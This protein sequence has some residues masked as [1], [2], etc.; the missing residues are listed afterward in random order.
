[1][2]PSSIAL[3]AVSLSLLSPTDLDAPVCPEIEVR[4]TGPTTVLVIPAMSARWQVWEGFM[5][6]NAD[7]YTTWAVTP[8]GFAGAPVPD[9]PIDA[10]VG[11]PWTDH[12]VQAVERVLQE[13]DLKDVV[14]LG[15]S[16]GS[17]IAIHIANRNPDRIRAIINTDGMVS[18]S[19]DWESKPETWR[20]EADKEISQWRER[21]NDP[22]EWASF[23]G[24]RDPPDLTRRSHMVYG[25]NMSTPKEVVL[26]CWREMWLWDLNPMLRS[27]QIPV[28]DIRALRSS[29]SDP[30]N[31]RAQ[32]LERL[33]DIGVPDS[34]HAVFLY[35]TRH[36][37]E[38]QRPDVFDR[39]V[40]EFLEGE[41]PSDWRPSSNKHQAVDPGPTS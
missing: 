9:L 21:F 30:E 40:A 36:A 22:E 5:D 19:I 26:Q 38:G 12:A 11:T 35:D 14:L 4:G 37:V 17:G 24:W 18:T 32:Y 1:M 25:M 6:R 34:H 2:I 13:N 33:D 39:L 20:S 31:T 27:L 15:H 10:P 7:R 3:V 28:L 29:D 23:N 41:T 8:P 16:W